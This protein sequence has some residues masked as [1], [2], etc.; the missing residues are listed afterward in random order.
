[1]KIKKLNKKRRKLFKLI[2][3]AKNGDTLIYSLMGLTLLCF[4][5]YIIFRT[6]Y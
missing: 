1:M 4:A 5:I 2:V 3:R 6:P